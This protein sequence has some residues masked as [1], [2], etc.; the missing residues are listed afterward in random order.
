[1]SKTL[2]TFSGKFGDILWSLPTARQV[3]QESDERKVDFAVMPAYKSLL[4]LLEFQSWID[5]AF[6]IDDWIC[7]GSPCGDQPWCAP[8]PA[9][10]SYKRVCHLTYRAHP[11]MQGTPAIALCDYT[12][13]QQGVHLKRPVVPFIEAQPIDVFPPPPLPVLCYSFNGDYFTPKQQFLFRLITRTKD[14]ISWTNVG[15]L[16][17]MQAASLLSQGNPFI[18]CRSACWV[19]AMGLGCQ[20]L[21]YEP[22]PSRHM[23]GPWGKVFSC[24]YGKEHAL[25]MD[26]PF[27]AADE[28]ADEILAWRDKYWRREKWDGRTV[29]TA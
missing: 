21:T 17:W 4:P 14:L 27:L 19:L 3:A 23:A 22:N 8:E 20:T 29:T 1:M 9:G 12:A 25:R 6:V 10:A 7:T 5:K 28:A 2:V 26:S 24:P 11:G 13:W 18:G 16:P 15:E